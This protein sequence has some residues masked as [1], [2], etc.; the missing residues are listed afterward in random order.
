MRFDLRPAQTPIIKVA[1][2]NRWVGAKG[3][4]VAV[5][6]PS[7]ETDPLVARVVEREGPCPRAQSAFIIIAM[8]AVATAFIVLTVIM[9]SVRS[10]VTHAS[11]VIKQP[12]NEVLNI[13]VHAAQDV[14]ATL[15]NV[16]GMS[17]GSRMVT[18]YSAGEIIEM[19]NSTK[20]IVT[21]MEA[22]LAHPN[23]NLELVPRIG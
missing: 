11:S 7:K 8:I 6:V 5:D 20:N 2:A 23:L 16:L 15:E 9:V 1:H 4:E 13:S 10:T 21:R 12:L 17:D 3:G 22:M 18:D 14:G 19:V